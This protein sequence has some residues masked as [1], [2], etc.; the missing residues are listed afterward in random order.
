MCEAVLSRVGASGGVKL[1]AKSISIGVIQ[2]IP[3]AVVELLWVDA[4]A[5]IFRGQIAVIAS[6]YVRASGDFQ[7]IANSIEVGVVHAFPCA[8]VGEIGVSAR[9]IVKLG[10]GV[11]IACL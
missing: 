5:G 8:I 3:I 4:V 7:L 11:V 1:I 10:G 6:L 9:A 2:A